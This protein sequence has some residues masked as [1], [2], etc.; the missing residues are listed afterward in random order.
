MNTIYLIRDT[1]N[2]LNNP[3]KQKIDINKINE[4]LIKISKD[5]GFTPP[6]LLESIDDDFNK[7][8]EYLDN[9]AGSI[10][11][12][13]EWS[14][15]DKGFIDLIQE[16]K[17]HSSSKSVCYN[18]IIKFKNL[19][20]D[21]KLAYEHFS[22]Y[23]SLNSPLDF[24][25]VNRKTHDYS[26]FQK[27][28]DV[29]YEKADDFLWLYGR[30]N[31]CRSKILLCAI[32]NSWVNI[33]TAGLNNCGELLY[34]S[35]F[36]VDIIKVD[37]NEVFV[38]LGAYIGDTVA[39]YID[40]YGA[41]YKRIYCYEID[42]LNFLH[43]TQNF[44]KYENII[45]I[46]KGVSDKNEMGFTIGKDM[47]AKLVESSTDENV[48]S[49]ETVTLD[50]DILEPITFLKIDIEGGEYNA[51]K[52]AAKHIAND[53]PKLAISVYHIFEDYIRIPRLIDEICPGY[54]FYLR[55]SFESDKIAPFNICL[56]GVYDNGKEKI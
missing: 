20:E 6:N 30:L 11:K 44:G 56:L 13:E 46:N 12:P 32:V 21:L 15:I 51:I 52:G 24:G 7:I 18:M 5:T 48:S 22:E 53:K 40:T 50:E 33:N 26:L 41:K 14:P 25:I 19:N 45:L 54:S 42:S 55:T 36:D 9:V 43:L 47:Q 29:L 3:N 16:I 49:I 2:L 23:W 28:A 4:S 1:F 17:S 38:D 39:D 10:V 8:F 34:A 31:D 37:S 35:N 27:R